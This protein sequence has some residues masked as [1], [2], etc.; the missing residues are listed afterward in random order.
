MDLFWYFDYYNW[1]IEVKHKYKTN[2]VKGKIPSKYDAMACLLRI[3]PLFLL[4]NWLT[5]FSNININ[6]H[7]VF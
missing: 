3:I 4:V 2:S 6:K 5:I 1:K 7:T